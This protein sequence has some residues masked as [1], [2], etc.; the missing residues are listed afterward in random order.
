MQVCQRSIRLS[1]LAAR[2]GPRL[3][4]LFTP[5]GGIAP[6]KIAASDCDAMSDTAP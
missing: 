1:T 4:P 6:D 5:E 2:I 3:L